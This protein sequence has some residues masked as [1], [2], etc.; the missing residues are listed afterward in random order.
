[1]AALAKNEGFKSRTQ[2]DLLKK[3]Q[4][5]AQE[6]HEARAANEVAG[7]EEEEEA[8]GGSAAVANLFSDLRQCLGI[9]SK[10]FPICILGS[11]LCSLLLKKTKFS[12]ANRQ[13][14]IG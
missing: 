11:G 12:L 1:M 14:Q 13:Y 5:M 3:L 8:T 10:Y 4:S 2:S 9:G 6:A 7:E